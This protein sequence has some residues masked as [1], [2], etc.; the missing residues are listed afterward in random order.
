M[1]A[2]TIL[3]IYIV[4]LVAGGLAGYFKA[5]SRISLYMALGFAAALAL[6]GVRLLPAPAADWL[7]AA[8]IVVFAL[9]LGKT[10]RLMPAGMMLAV[11]IVALAGRHLLG[12]P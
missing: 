10:K 6:C 7:M 3:W 8:L 5:K 4:L 9:R 11:T 2:T 1:N 12:H